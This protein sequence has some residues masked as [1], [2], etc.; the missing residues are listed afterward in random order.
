MKFLTDHSKARLVLSAIALGALLAATP[1]CVVEDID[2]D[3]PE[4]VG[5]AASEITWGVNGHSYLFRPEPTTWKTAKATCASKTGYQ[6]LTINNS[7][8]QAWLRQQA[9]NLDPDS[10]WWIG[11]N[12]LAVETVWSWVVKGTD[13]TNWN[14]GQ[15]NQYNYQDCASMSGATGLWNDTNC[16]T[17]LNYICERNY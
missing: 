10:Q 15:P 4:N 16:S 6:L 12:D 2:E 13:Y 5:E 17:A 11:Y 9:Q 1:G 8:E 14:P 7:N 3:G